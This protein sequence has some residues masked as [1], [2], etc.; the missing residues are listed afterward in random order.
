MSLE[1]WGMQERD[2]E[3]GQS[4]GVDGGLGRPH[5]QS[6]LAAAHQSMRK[7]EE[8]EVFRR[9]SQISKGKAALLEGDGWGAGLILTMFL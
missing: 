4:W 5:T 7:P 6:L 1:I 9:L 8:G 3:M 2:W